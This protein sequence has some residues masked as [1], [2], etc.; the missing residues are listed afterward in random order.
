MSCKTTYGKKSNT[1]TTSFPVQKPFTLLDCISPGEENL[2]P[3]VQNKK[4]ISKK[5]NPMDNPTK[6][7][8]TQEGSKV[9][10]SR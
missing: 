7:Q 5:S 4:A 3:K 8:R 10:C 6:K 1:S 9:T 2:T